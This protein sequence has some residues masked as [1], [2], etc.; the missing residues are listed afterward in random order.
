LVVID[1]VDFGQLVFAQVG[2]Q[3]HQF[4]VGLFV[5]GG[6]S[7]D[8]CG[9]ALWVVMVGDTISAVVTQVWGA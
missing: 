6:D 7:V 9:C 3:T 2:P 8:G 1:G 5:L 4:G